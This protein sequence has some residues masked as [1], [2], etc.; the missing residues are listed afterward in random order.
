MGAWRA[1]RLPAECAWDRSACPP[2]HGT[3][4]RCEGCDADGMGGRVADR[5][6]NMLCVR[7]RCA[8]TAR[9]RIR[10]W[11][12]DV[13]QYLSNELSAGVQESRGTSRRSSTDGTPPR[14]C[15]L[16]DRAPSEHPKP[17]QPHR[18]RVHRGF[19]T[20]ECPTQWSASYGRTA[21]L[22]AESSMA[23]NRGMSGS[24]PAA[25]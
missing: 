3:W 5:R 8:P 4:I 12:F 15:R 7:V 13:W 1:C 9:S 16:H 20:G 24:S 17:S 22:P 2:T 11:I 19:H 25:K 10:Y 14:S 6:R 21:I 23:R 18:T